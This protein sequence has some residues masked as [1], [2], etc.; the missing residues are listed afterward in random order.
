MKRRNPWLVV[1]GGVI[2]LVVV[3]IAGVVGYWRYANQL[4]T[5]PT[6]TVVMP[7]PNAYDDYVAAG[8]LCKAAGGASLPAP[9]LRPP[10]R[11]APVR[12]GNPPGFGTGP[13]SGYP[14]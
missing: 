2:G 6:P 13:G 7:V 12:V 9:P 4:P 3:I 10:V 1:G 14:G 11:P 8:Q 5:Y